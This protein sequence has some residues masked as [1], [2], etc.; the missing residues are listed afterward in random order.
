MTL[1]Q[2]LEKSLQMDRLRNPDT[3]FSELKHVEPSVLEEWQEEWRPRGDFWPVIT[4]RFLVLQKLRNNEEVNQAVIDELKADIEARDIESHYPFEA[5]FLESL[6]SYKQSDRGMFPQWNDPFRILYQFFYTKQEKLETHQLLE[7]L[8]ND[9]ILRHQLDNARVHT[10]GFDGAQNYGDSG[11]WAAIIPAEAKGPRQAYQI[12][13][14]VNQGQLEGGLLKG[15]SLRDKALT[16]EKKDYKSWEDYLQDVDRFIDQWRQL[17]SKLDF[18]FTQDE[19]QFK[20]CLKGSSA[21]E[22]EIYF[23]M[24]DKLITDLS[25]PNEENI[26]FL[27]EP[28]SKKMIF[29]VGKRY[30]LNLKKDEFHFL[31]PKKYKLDDVKVTDKVQHDE[32]LFYRGANSAA[33]QKHYKPIAEAIQQELEKEEKPISKNKDNTAFRRAVFDKEYRKTLT[34]ADGNRITPNVADPTS[35]EKINLILFGPPGTGKTYYT[36]NEAVKIINPQFYKAHKDPGSRKWLREEF[37]RLLI[38]NWEDP[39]GQIAF[40]TFHQSFSY[41]DFVEGIKPKAGEDGEISYEIESGVFKRICELAESNYSAIKVIKGGKLSWSPE[42][43]KKASFF[44]ISLGDVTNEGDQEIYEYCRD[45]KCISIGF[46]QNNDFSGMSEQEIEDKCKESYL[47]NEAALQMKYFIHHLKKGDYVLVSHGNKYLRAMGK[48]T[49]DYF[50]ND[51]PS[52]K[53]NHFRKVEWLF[54]DERI[55]VEE[56]YDKTFTQNTLYK[57][58][59]SGLKKE[60]FTGEGQRESIEQKKDKRYVLIIDEINRGNIANIFGE[61]ITL[62]EKDKRAGQKEALEV[63]LPYSKIRFKVPPNLYIIGTMNTADRSIE[64]LDT[65]LRRRFSFREM[66]PEPELIKT[67]GTLKPGGIIK[68]PHNGEEINVVKLLNKIN[69]RIEKLIDKDHKIGH[70]YF[71]HIT[72]LAELNTA[73]KDKVIPLLEEYFFGDFGKIGLVLGNS[74]VERVDHADFDFAEFAGYNHDGGV[75]QDLAERPVYRIKKPHEPGSW[76]FTD[77][78]SDKK[79]S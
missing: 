2:L 75:T 65:A 19:E 71:M 29:Q 70:S 15:H 51:N 35:D 5:D 76:N 18:H 38:K 58:D 42:K 37:N 41:E 10:V 55:S 57:I 68:N 78:Y 69:E 40:C 25:I 49:G 16:G 73:F 12:F 46:G 1:E 74:F 47:S 52:I 54:V 53:H 7:D 9:I 66:A 36:V 21:R 59:K 62:I 27:V 22:L 45:N 33:V 20:K 17:N 67:T 64:A 11:A 43:F 34:N 32:A 79:T 60:F 72:N 31:A 48:V 50:Y 39:K 6:K 63:V 56:V 26:V 30:C 3:L 14:G 4:L 77:V 24:L 8:G 28:Q 61:L 23:S 13:Y 44:K